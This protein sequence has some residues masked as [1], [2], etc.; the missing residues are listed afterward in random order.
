M[1]EAAA[2]PRRRRWRSW[3]WKLPLAFVAFS[4]LQVLVL[5]FVDPPFSMFMAA[6]QLDALV[7]GDLEF[8]IAH[9]WRDMDKLSPN[10]P[11]ALVASEDQNFARH[12]GFDFAARVLFLHEF[13][14]RE[15]PQ[16]IRAHVAREV[17]RGAA[18]VLNPPAIE[19]R[20]ES[21]VVEMIKANQPLPKFAPR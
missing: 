1:N 13:F 15:L 10:L 9:D 21:A 16:I 7:A 8:R 17:P 11:L 19:V 12:H 5:R 2:V 4:V 20:F 3:L 6:R 14:R 18:P